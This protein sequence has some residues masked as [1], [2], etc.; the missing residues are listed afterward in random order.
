MTKKEYLEILLELVKEKI[1][2]A[3]ERQD[4]SYMKGDLM[5]WRDLK[6]TIKKDL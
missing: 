3:L 5:Y 1:K 4:T 6:K 2:Y